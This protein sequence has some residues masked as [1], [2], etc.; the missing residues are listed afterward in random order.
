MVLVQLVH[1]KFEK[2][3][4][5]HKLL[6]T[7]EHYVNIRMKELIHRFGSN[8]LLRSVT[9]FFFLYSYNIYSFYLGFSAVCVEVHHS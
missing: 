4:F 2:M 9:N 8:L 1:L 3:L 7:S 5:F 6:R